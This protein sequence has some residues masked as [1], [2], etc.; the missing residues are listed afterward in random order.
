MFSPKRK[1]SSTLPPPKKKTHKKKIKV[2]YSLCKVYWPIEDQWLKLKHIAAR[3]ERFDQYLFPPVPKSSRY[4][5]NSSNDNSSERKKTDFTHYINTMT[6]QDSN[7]HRVFTCLYLFCGKKLATLV[8]QGW[9]F[10]FYLFQ[11]FHQLH[12]ICLLKTKKPKGQ[13][14]NLVPTTSKL[15]VQVLKHE[16]IILFA[17]KGNDKLWVSIHG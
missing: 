11:P 2:W 16:N 12:G 10:F 9:H 15:K 4:Q 7:T 17:P 3:L 5:K 13:G 6:L 8:L 1:V 14:E